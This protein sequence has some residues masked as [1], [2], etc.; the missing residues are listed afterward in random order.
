MDMSMARVE[1]NR[2]AGSRGDGIRLEFH[3]QADLAGNRIDGNQGCAVATGL[4]SIGFE[5]RNQ[6]TGNGQCATPDLQ[7]L[8][9][10]RVSTGGLAVILVTGGLLLLLPVALGGHRWPVYMFVAAAVVQIFHQLEHVAQVVQAHVLGW[11]TPHGLA[12]AAID[13]E[14]VHI[15]FNSV[16]TIAL[17]AILLGY[18]WSGVSSWAKR[19]RVSTATLLAGVALQGYHQVEHLVKIVQHTTLGTT[20][21]PGI[22][23]NVFDLVWLHFWINLAVTVAVVVGLLG[24]GIVRHVGPIRRLAPVPV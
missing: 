23:G 10:P 13:T 14:W 6:T 16:L 20:P 12:G 2:V 5:R 1:R 22:L 17:A 15:G 18:G 7:P 21:A 4:G 9:I 19:S 3:S 8:E 11:K 24:L